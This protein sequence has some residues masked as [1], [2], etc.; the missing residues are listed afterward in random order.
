MASVMS[1]L[2]E[3]LVLTKFNHLSFSLVL[4]RILGVQ[5]AHILFK[6]LWTIT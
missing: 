3:R 1:K 4:K 5:S 6:R 2:F